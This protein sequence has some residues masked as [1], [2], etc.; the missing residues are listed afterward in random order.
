MKNIGI[1]KNNR[2][3]FVWLWLII[4]VT[5]LLALGT[6]YYLNQSEPIPV[7]SK[8]LLPPSKDA[9]DRP[10]HEVA[11]EVADANYFT[12]NINP[13]VEFENGESNGN[14]QIINS[15][16]NVYPIA[17]VIIL[18]DTEEQIYSSGAIY[19]NQQILSGRL[20]VALPKGEYLATATVTIYDPDTKEKR[21]VT[22]AEMQIIIRN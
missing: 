3:K 4:L 1:E 22:Q 5:S 12:L 11:Q 10:I 16:S 9:A 18:N 21:G 17:V 13:I 7:I 14:I 2:K 15:E 6:W 19:P 8:D 20:E